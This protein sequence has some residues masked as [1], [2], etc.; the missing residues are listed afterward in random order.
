LLAGFQISENRFKTPDFPQTA[1]LSVL[2]ASLELA[3]RA[4][5]MPE[6]RR[7]VHHMLKEYHINDFNHRMH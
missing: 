1:I 3:A 4:A 6:I 5:S 7:D 2:E